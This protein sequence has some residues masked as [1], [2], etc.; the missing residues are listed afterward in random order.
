M[1]VKDSIHFKIIV[2]MYNCSRWAVKCLESVVNQTHKNWQ[3]IICVE[4]S[5]DNTKDVVRKYLR[6]KCDSRMVLIENEV[7]KHVP[8]NH[9]ECI[10]LSEPENED[11]IVL[12]D[13]D[14]RLSDCQAIAYLNDIYRDPS[15]WITWGSYVFAHNLKLRGRASE[16][17]PTE[18]DEHE[19][20]RWWRFSHLKT[21][22]YFLFKGIQDNDLRDLQTHEYYIVAGDMALMFPM[23]EMAGRSHSKYID[24]VLYVYN[25]ST[26]YNDEKT[27][28][29]LVKRCDSEI[30]N[31][32]KY[33]EKTKEE[34]CQL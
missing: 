19:G 6:S 16:P 7:Q 31:R 3:M 17:F 26:P 23:I 30:R 8:R 10:K 11:V 9:I 34:L 25:Q 24:R 28:R 27:H 13:G 21:F 18:K 12:V 33:I 5:Q 29:L 4:P 20:E 1:E 14:D 2:P 15:I 22:R 32:P